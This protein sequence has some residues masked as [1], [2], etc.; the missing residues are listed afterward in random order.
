MNSK[1]NW[2]NGGTTEQTKNQKRKRSAECTPA[3]KNEKP[4]ERTRETGWTAERPSGQL[5]C[6]QF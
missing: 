5:F 2:A 4:S 6:L 1:K 3:K